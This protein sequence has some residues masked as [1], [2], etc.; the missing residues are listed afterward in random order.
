L[1]RNENWWKAH[2]EKLREKWKKANVRQAAR[3]KVSAKKWRER[4]SQHVKDVKRAWQSRNRERLAIYIKEYGEKNKE[5]LRAQRQA[6][7]KANRAKSIANGQKRRAALAK[8]ASGN[9]DLILQFVADIKAKRFAICYYCQ[10]KTDTHKIH[11]DHII[12]LAK[13][14]Q[15]SVENLCVSCA[16]CN[17]TKH[18]RTPQAWIRVGQQLLAL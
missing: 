12:P 10:Q 4:N 9:L 18:D 6:Y 1:E 15:H 3:R 5:K 7:W 2:P 11:F 16:K 14:G 8:Q 17:L 13:G